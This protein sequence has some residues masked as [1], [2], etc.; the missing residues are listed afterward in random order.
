MNLTL[1]I[2]LFPPGSFPGPRGL[3]EAWYCFD[4]I[5][6]TSSI[7]HI[8]VISVDRCIG[9]KQPLWYCKYN[10]V[11]YIKLKIVFTWLLVVSLSMPA[12]LLHPWDTSLAYMGYQ[13]CG[14]PCR[15]SVV[16]YGFLAFLLP[17]IV[18]GVSL[19]LAIYA[20]YL[21]YKLIRTDIHFCTSMADES[22]GTTIRETSSAVP[23]S[24]SPSFQVAS[25][26]ASFKGAQRKS[27]SLSNF[28]G[29]FREARRGKGAAERIQG[30]VAR[31]NWT[32]IHH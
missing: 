15:K 20:I 3:A 4:L 12:F 10:T 22:F 2:V 28:N 5:F 24:R 11:C 25:L 30:Q 19:T 27:L 18:T 17:I 13:I 16:V 23:R 8:C 14:K 9:L 26:N 31:P 1:A 29:S 21:G 6:M 7:V 32:D